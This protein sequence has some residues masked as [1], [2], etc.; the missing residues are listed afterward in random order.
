MTLPP[1]LLIRIVN[2]MAR[3]R[4]WRHIQTWPSTASAKV[5]RPDGGGKTSFTPVQAVMT[6]PTTKLA[7]SA[8]IA[9]GAVNACTAAPA[10]PGPTRL[11]TV[12]LDWILVFA[13]TNRSRPASAG[14]IAGTAIACTVA[15][16][17]AAKATTYSWPIVRW[18][19]RAAAGMGAGAAALTAWEAKRVGVRRGR[20]SPNPAR[21]PK[22]E[23]GPKP[24]RP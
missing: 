9:S 19:R 14:T 8:A 4:G 13:C 17:P 18:W 20:A 10:S 16:A 1:A 23:P 22:R 15:A 21:D 24:I 3:T 2:V 12:R 11:E 7:A 5:L 6:A